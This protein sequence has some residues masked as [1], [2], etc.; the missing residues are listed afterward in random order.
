MHVFHHLWLFSLPKNVWFSSVW[1]S[2]YVE[3]LAPSLHKCIRAYSCRC[4]PPYLCRSTPPWLIILSWNCSLNFSLFRK[5]ETRSEIGTSPLPLVRKFHAQMR[6]FCGGD[7]TGNIVVLQMFRIAYRSISELYLGSGVCAL[8]TEVLYI[9]IFRTTLHSS[10]I[11]YIVDLVERS[12]ASIF[13]EKPAPW[14]T[15]PSSLFCQN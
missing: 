5:K 12:K 13:L 2:L 14:S 7:Q 4:T 3:I 6:K 8:Y 15:K 11:K 1:M 9:Y 10:T